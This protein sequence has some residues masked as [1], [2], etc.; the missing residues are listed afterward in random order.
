MIRS[1][2][3]GFALTCLTLACSSN[4]GAPD[5]T[6]GDEGESQAA[7]T[8][9]PATQEELHQPTLASA[10]RDGQC[11]SQAD[12]PAGDVCTAVMPGEAT[13]VPARYAGGDAMRPA[14]NGRPGAPVGLLD[15]Q[16]L[17]EHVM[18][19]QPVPPSEQP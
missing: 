8:A 11:S 16:V 6:P 1:L 14:P 2:V 9:P 5:P 19:E 13:C 15:G 18:H 17:R 10:M 4:P 7:T 12:C 3:V